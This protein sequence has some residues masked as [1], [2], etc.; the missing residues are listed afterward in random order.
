MS[1]YALRMQGICKRFPGVHA[2]DGVHLHVRKGTVHG[3]MGENG[4]GK[5]TLMKCLIGM[6]AP[7]EGTIEVAGKP[8]SIH[9][10]HHAL[11]L[12]ISMIHQ[13]LSPI[14][15]MT[16]AENIYLGREP[17]TWYGLV[18]TRELNRRTAELLGRLG[19][20]VAP[21]RRMV[22]LS[23][24]N[25]QLVEIAKAI[26]YD[27][28]LIIM[29]EP[30]S[31]ITEAEVAN[32]HR[33]IRSLRDRGVSI[34]YITHK[35]DEVFSI[36]DDITVLRDGRF[37]D[38][39][40]IQSLTH[41]LLIQKM[42]G[43]ELTR[44]FEKEAA[45]VGEPV[46]EVRNY[47]GK[48]FRDV[49]FQVRRGE[50]LGVAGLMGAGRTELLETIFGVHRRTSGEIFLHG[51]RV[52]IDQPADS[53]RHGLALLTEDRKLTGLYLN[54]TV[55]DNIS[56]ANLRRYL[57]GPF[58]QF[59]KV[60][61]DCERM[62]KAMRIKTPTLLQKVRNL[63]GGNQQKVLLARWLL[64]EPEILILDEPTR[65]IDVGAKAEIY[66]LMVDLARSGKAII[67]ISSE[68]PEVLGMCDRIMVMHEGEK[69]G[70]LQRS[71]AT[72]ERVLEMATG[73]TPAA[74][75]A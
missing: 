6:Y 3:L 39:S 15:Q 21:E 24:A 5:S 38:A 61:A 55:R 51:K 41:D 64:T 13:E 32:L 37:V 73:L 9:G 33:I 56:I 43:R 42:V 25:T 75:N 49:S 74:A 52:R 18:D 29:D 30:T 20:A 35:M 11:S 1:E 72:Q 26:S 54:A 31:A 10:T 4:A 69:V 28:G 47:S 44:M 12:G 36:C 23:I 58:V 34:I 70:E 19:I 68:M 63:S 60:A 53:I 8:V 46:L 17:L 67:M 22:E 16:V 71:S 65:G 40:P 14:P 50:I 59:G 7:D 45:P 48:R 57:A 66:R 62:R 2:L 27:S